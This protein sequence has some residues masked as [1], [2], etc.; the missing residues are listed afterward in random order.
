MNPKKCTPLSLTN[1]SELAPPLMCCNYS[2][3]QKISI[4]ELFVAWLFKIQPKT[5]P[6]QKYQLWGN[7]RPQVKTVL[8][9]GKEL[10]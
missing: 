5:D 4:Y 9:N 3:F 8:P 2:F 7:E 10:S 1:I 6:N